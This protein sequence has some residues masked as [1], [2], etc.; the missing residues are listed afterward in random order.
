MTDPTPLYLHRCTVA[1]RAVT[2]Q[3]ALIC[4]HLVAEHAAVFSRRQTAPSIG[5]AI[6]HACV[7]VLETRL[8]RAAE[9]FATETAYLPV[10]LAVT[11]LVA[12]ENRHDE[13]ALGRRA[14]DLIA[15]HDAQ[16]GGGF[17]HGPALARQAAHG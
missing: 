8:S 14:R 2:G 11:R 1:L 5:W 3:D 4:A 9:G 12:D 13:T 6:R 17:G 15:H 7:E 10:A 16:A